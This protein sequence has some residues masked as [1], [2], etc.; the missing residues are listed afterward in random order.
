MK[1]SILSGKGGT[2]KTTVA[3]NLA[4]TLGYMYV[5][6]DVEEPNGF[7]F[8][9]PKIIKDNEVKVLVPTIDYDKCTLC[10]KCVKACQ[11]N[12]IANTGKDIMIFEKLCHSCGTCVLVCSQDAIVEKSRT[13]GKID[14]GETAEIKC[15][16]GLLTVGEPM[17]GPIISQ[18]KGMID[19]KD[20]L[21]DCAPGSSCNVVKAII[22]TD[23]A[24]LVTEP[25][26]FGLHDLHIATQL[27]RKMGIPFGVIINRSDEYVNLITDYCKDNN[28]TI[29]GQIPFD[30]K[31]ANLYSKGKLLVE[32][33]E[34]RS[35]FLEIAQKL[36]G[37]VLCS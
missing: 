9:K 30:K 5:D 14:I 11:F 18:I 22:D 35:M 15:I 21:I 19:D 23:Y 12:A 29:L 37:V 3:T 34:Y 17:A 27:V 33:N 25:T 20:V 7:I 24:I 2:G 1:I 32:D 26:K 4:K 16:R 10:G 6:C 28:I 13:I 36:K 31:I 8:L